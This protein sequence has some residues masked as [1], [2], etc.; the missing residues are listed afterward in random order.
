M[1][2]VRRAISPCRTIPWRRDVVPGRTN[3]FAATSG[4]ARQ[5]A[6][7]REEYRRFT[8]RVPDRQPFAGPVCLQERVEIWR[9]AVIGDIDLAAPYAGSREV[10]HTPRVAGFGGISTCGVERRT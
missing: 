5:G 4:I 1:G 6:E 7:P 9:I 3:R 8:R 2:S 10:A